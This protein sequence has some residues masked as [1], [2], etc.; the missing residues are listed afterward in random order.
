MPKIP[1]ED[2][3][4]DILGKAM[5]GLKLNDTEVAQQSGV[6]VPELQTL[7]AGAFSTAVAAKVAPV[8]GLNPNAL[9]ALAEQRY[10]PSDVT[11]EGLAQFNTPFEDMTVNAYL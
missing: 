1:L 6:G 11:L 10:T 9:A 8:L 7:R 2:N 5:R 4:T 3:Y